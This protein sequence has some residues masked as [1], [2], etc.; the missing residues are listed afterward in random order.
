MFNI[1]SN[2]E[3][4]NEFVGIKSLLYEQATIRDQLVKVSKGLDH[5]NLRLHLEEYDSDGLQLLSSQLD[6]FL[7]L[8]FALK[9]CGIPNRSC[10]LNIRT[11]CS[12]FRLL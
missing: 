12:Q 4:I 6:L 5:L 8:Q 9:H 10:N 2:I 1:A 11:K 7:I 3:E